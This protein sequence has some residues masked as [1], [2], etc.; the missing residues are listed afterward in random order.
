MGWRE[1]LTE[2]AREH[3]IT[4]LF[5]L[6]VLLLLVIWRAVPSSIWDGVSEAVPKPVL[7]ALIALELIVIGLLT[8]FALDNRRK[9]KRA[10]PPSDESKLMIAFGCLWDD[11]QNPLCPADKTLMYVA[12]HYKDEGYETIRCPKCK[13]RIPLR[14][15][16]DGLL[17]LAGAR[18]VIRERIAESQK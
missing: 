12:M 8:A 15:D 9:S 18:D 13:V 3:I 1:T 14:D 6:I 2:K 4:I 17:T 5:G 11:S 10:I 16:E 7:W